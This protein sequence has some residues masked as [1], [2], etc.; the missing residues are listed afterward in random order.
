MQCRGEGV[1]VRNNNTKKTY[2]GV[3]SGGR[4]ASTWYHLGNPF[5]W[6][7]LQS[8]GDISF[9]TTPDNSNATPPNCEISSPSASQRL[10]VHE[11]RSEKTPAQHVIFAVLSS[12]P[13]EWRDLTA[14]EIPLL[15]NKL[16]F[17]PSLPQDRKTAWFR[18]CL[19]GARVLY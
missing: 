16:P 15:S 19:P 7:K 18:R 9:I 17:L 6:Q 3:A 4:D 8:P 14:P 12:C 2:V 5:C 1:E 11:T 13:T 10:P